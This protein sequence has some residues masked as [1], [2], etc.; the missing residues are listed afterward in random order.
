MN[1]I[2]REEGPIKLG[3]FHET[4]NNVSLDPSTA[5]KFSFNNENR[6]EQQ[7]G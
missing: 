1:N 7:S 6:N 2:T 5:I 4:D 3:T